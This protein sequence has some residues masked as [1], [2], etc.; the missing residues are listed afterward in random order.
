M[1]LL[2]VWSP[3]KKT[4]ATYDMLYTTFTYYSY[5]CVEIYLVPGMLLLWIIV[6]RLLLP[7]FRYITIYTLLTTYTAE[8]LLLLYHSSSTHSCLLWLRSNI[9]DPQCIGAPGN[10]WYMV[11]NISY[12]ILIASSHR[13]LCNNGM[14]IQ[15]CSRPVPGRPT[16]CT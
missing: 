2:V 3:A 14:Y 12:Y 11:N 7:L 9:S 4:A 16:T 5:C 1:V 15:L 6:P 10:Y 8:E 13:R